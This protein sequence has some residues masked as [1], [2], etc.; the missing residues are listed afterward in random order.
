VNRLSKLSNPFGPRLN[1]TAVPIPTVCR[2]FEAAKSVLCF[3]TLSEAKNLASID[4]CEK[5]QRE[6][7]RF[8]QNDNV[9]SF[10]ADRQAA[11]HKDPL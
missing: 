2:P 1:P 10:S 5:E 7:L 4:V 6:I 8:A 3:V 9:L 11:T